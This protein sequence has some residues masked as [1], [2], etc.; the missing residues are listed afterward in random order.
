MKKKDYYELLSDHRW[1][2]LLLNCPF[3]VQI[4]DGI[5]YSV[6]QMHYGN[7]FFK[8]ELEYIKLCIEN[9]LNKYEEDNLSDCDIKKRD[10]VAFDNFI[11]N[12]RTYKQKKE[13]KS[14]DLYLIHDII[15]DKLKIGRSNNAE[16]RLKQLQ[17]ATSNKLELLFV[18]E[19]KGY[20]EAQIHSFFNCINTNSEWFENDGQ[21]IKYFKEEL[22]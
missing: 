18:I 4:K 13:K 15:L 9:T 20:L 14:D 22:L 6:D 12:N 2:K 17:I 19:G 5:F 8:E 7:L 16:S 10:E 3:C 11:N 21:I 1:Q